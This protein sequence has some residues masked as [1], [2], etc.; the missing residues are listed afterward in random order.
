MNGK[1]DVRVVTPELAEKVEVLRL[2][3]DEK[4]GFQRRLQMERVKRMSHELA[5]G[6]VCP[7]ILLG[8]LRDKLYLLDGQHRFEAWK[9]NPQFLLEAK[10]VKLDDMRQAKKYFIE[11]NAHQ[12]R[13]GLKHRLAVDPSEF[14][15]RLRNIAKEYGLDPTSVNALVHGVMGAWHTSS[16]LYS[17][18]TEEDWKKAT[19]ILNVWRNDKRWGKA[20]NIYSKGATLRVVAHIAAQSKDFTS[21]LNEIKTMDFSQGGRLSNV[22]GA[23]ASAQKLMRQLIFDHIAKRVLA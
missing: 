16:D 23:S 19:N 10:V 13:V 20:T 18:V 1:S 14:A 12:V 3:D 21:A 4:N 11:L 5:N 17:R 2:K 7:P 8:N 15:Y 6:S 22:C 9:L